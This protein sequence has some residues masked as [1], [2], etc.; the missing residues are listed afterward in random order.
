MHNAGMWSVTADHASK[1][2]VMSCPL[3]LCLCSLEHVYCFSGIWTS[4]AESYGA[5]LSCW[6]TASLAVAA[7]ECR[8]HG[9]LHDT[10]IRSCAEHDHSSCHLSAWGTMSA[11]AYCLC[12]RGSNN[13]RGIARGPSADEV[14]VTVQNDG[15]VCY[16]SARQVNRTHPLAVISASQ[17]LHAPCFVAQ[18]CRPHVEACDTSLFAIVCSEQDSQVSHKVVLL[19]I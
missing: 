13:V 4:Y 16:S 6:Q 9:L 8:H 3:Y 12:P 18:F 19:C 7:L 14:L 5:P 1:G 10:A 17:G 15:V 2:D 11:S